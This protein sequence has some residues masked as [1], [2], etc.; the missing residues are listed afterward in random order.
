MKGNRYVIDCTGLEY[1]CFRGRGQ[2]F[3]FQGPEST[4]RPP[5][6]DIVI[7]AAHATA[8]TAAVSRMP[9]AQTER[10]FRSIPSPIIWP[11]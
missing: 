1:L 3:L 7:D 8:I 2:Y 6:N 5:A 9:S 10:C 4:S 11:Y